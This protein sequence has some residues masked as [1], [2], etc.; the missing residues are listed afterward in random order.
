[1]SVIDFD[2]ARQ[3]LASSTPPHPI[4]EALDALAIALTDH[5]HSWTERERQLYETALSYLSGGYTGSDSPA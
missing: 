4:L 3:R 2:A 5:G 1:M